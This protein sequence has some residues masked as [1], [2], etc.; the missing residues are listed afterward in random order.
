MSPCL[1]GISLQQERQTD[2]L[3]P[4]EE[5][6]CWTVFGH[7]KGHF[8]QGVRDGFGSGADLWALSEGNVDI[9]KTQSRSGRVLGSSEITVV[10]G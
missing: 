2:G 1:L 10:E 4:T 7:T 5:S 9:L 8:G 3:Q 6:E